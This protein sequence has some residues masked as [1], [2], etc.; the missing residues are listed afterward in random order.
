[1]EPP[2]D[3]IKGWLYKA[4]R[5]SDDLFVRRAIS[6]NPQTGKF[7]TFHDDVKL[8]D[9]KSYYLDRKCVIEPKSASEI[10]EPQAKTERPHGQWSITALASGEGKALQLVSPWDV[11]G[12]WPGAMNRGARL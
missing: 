5:T 8:N 9:R 3:T 4:T 6:F 2:A 1:M 11:H 7:V 12:S 10:T